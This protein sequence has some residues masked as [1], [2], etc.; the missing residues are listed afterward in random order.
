MNP[1]ILEFNPAATLLKS[2]GVGLFAHPHGFTVDKNGNIWTTDTND[3][4]SI[5]GMPARNAQG[6]RDGPTRSFEIS[7][8]GRV[9]MTIGTPG[10][11]GKGPYAFDRPA[12]VAIAPSGDIFVADGHSPNKSNSGRVVKY[13]P[14]GTFVKEWG[15]VGSEPGNFKEPHDIFVGGSRGYV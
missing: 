12:G 4:D 10:V 5:L 14:D 6:A 11:S 8:A 1:P 13:R 15:R 9:L 7:P 3:D 2:F